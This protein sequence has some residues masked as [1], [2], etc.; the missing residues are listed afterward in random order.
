LEDLRRLRAN[1]LV[2]QFRIAKGDRDRAPIIG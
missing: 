2:P 1:G